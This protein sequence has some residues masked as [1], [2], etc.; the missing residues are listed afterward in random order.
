[1][2]RVL[3]LAILRGTASR[4][5]DAGAETSRARTERPVA[6]RSRQGVERRHS[7]DEGVERRPGRAEGDRGGKA[8]RKRGPTHGWLACVTSQMS[9]RADPRWE[10]CALCGAGTAGSSALV[11]S[12]V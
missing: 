12:Q 8:A 9:R 11:L 2:E 3:L 10:P 4:R 5:P 7:T 6:I 1:M